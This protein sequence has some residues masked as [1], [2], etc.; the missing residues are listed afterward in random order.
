[1][2]FD[3][4]SLQGRI[5]HRHHRKSFSFAPTGWAYSSALH[6]I[7]RTAS[8]SERHEVFLRS[9]LTSSMFM[10]MEVAFL[11]Q[12]AVKPFVKAYNCS[13]C[14][15]VLQAAQAALCVPRLRMLCLRSLICATICILQR[16]ECRRI[17]TNKPWMCSRASLWTSTHMKWYAVL[18]ESSRI[19]CCYSQEGRYVGCLFFR[20]RHLLQMLLSR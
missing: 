3:F 20:E 15:P 4:P 19:W 14:W 7:M 18:G 11:L 17:C 5:Q 2:S 10:D 9:W 12:R 6:E 1:M 13:E 8:A 16:G